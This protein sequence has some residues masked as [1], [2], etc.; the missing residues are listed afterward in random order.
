[1]LR[2]LSLFNIFSLN[3]TLQAQFFFF[4]RYVYAKCDMKKVFVYQKRFSTLSSFFFIFFIIIIIIVIVIII[5]FLLTKITK[6][7]ADK[8]GG[9]GRCRSGGLGMIYGCKGCFFLS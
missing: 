3:Y 6:S 2:S 7:Y 1:M 8:G 9:V 4:V 5:M